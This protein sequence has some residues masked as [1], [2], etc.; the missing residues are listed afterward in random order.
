[1][2]EFL[3]YA[4]AAALAGVIVSIGE[5]VFDAPKWAAFF[6]FVILMRLYMDRLT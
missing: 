5:L 2:K 1:M 6:T 3:D 4:L